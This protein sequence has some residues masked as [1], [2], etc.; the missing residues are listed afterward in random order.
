MQGPE[1]GTNRKLVKSN[2]KGH[3]SETTE[4]NER[5]RIWLVFIVA[6][7]SVLLKFFPVE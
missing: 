1:M 6:M 2:M 4:C 5:L 7:T 3:P